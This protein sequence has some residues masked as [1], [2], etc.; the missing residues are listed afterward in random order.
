MR[1]DKVSREGVMAGRPVPRELARSRVVWNGRRLVPG[2][3]G[4]LLTTA[5]E[6]S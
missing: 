6:G 4:R 1:V 3:R 2:G 5:V